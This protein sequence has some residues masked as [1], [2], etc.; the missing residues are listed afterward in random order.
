MVTCWVYAALSK[1]CTELLTPAEMA[2]VYSESRLVFNCSLRREVNM[3]VFEG[4]ATGSLLL[5]DRIGNG[6][7]ELMAD[8]THLVMYDDAILVERAGFR[9]GGFPQL[10]AAV[11]AR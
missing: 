8:R 4:P 10:E 7:S 5:T 1:V 11:H 2:R 9:D 6:L 3:R